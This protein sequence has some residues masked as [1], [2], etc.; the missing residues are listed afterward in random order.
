M[1]ARFPSIVGVVILGLSFCRFP[2]TRTFKAEP[3]SLAIVKAARQCMDA[4]SV[5]GSDHE[6]LDKMGVGGDR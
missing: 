4:S 2:L 5:V 3:R 6:G 1:I